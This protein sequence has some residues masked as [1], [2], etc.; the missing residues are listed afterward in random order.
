MID[1]QRILITFH[2]LLVASAAFLDYAEVV[3]DSDLISEG[4]FQGRE[5]VDSSLALAELLKGHCIVGA[6]LFV[7]GRLYQLT[8]RV[9]ATGGHRH[10]VARTG[11][12]DLAHLVIDHPDVVVRLRELDLVQLCILRLV[13]AGYAC[14][15]A[16]QRERELLVELEVE[17]P[18]VEIGLNVRLI[19]LQSPLVERLQLVEQ[20]LADLLWT[21]CSQVLHA[22]RD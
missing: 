5:G 12:L 6:G 20:C 16:L 8:L 22:V 11:H 19:L 7:G 9:V 2:G 1:P 10:E 4:V 3:V 17:E 13:I 18:K 15:E 21:G 14:F